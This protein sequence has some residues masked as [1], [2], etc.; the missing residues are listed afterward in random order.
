GGGSFTKWDVDGT[1]YSTAMLDR[2]ISSHK[3]VAKA[4][5]S[6]SSSGPTHVKQSSINSSF[7]FDDN[8]IYLPQ[9]IQGK[10]DIYTIDGKQVKSLGVA[11][12]R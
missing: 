5:F 4:V 7:N 9:A 2:T 3:T 1:D 12:D 10:A 6:G 8:Y 11:G